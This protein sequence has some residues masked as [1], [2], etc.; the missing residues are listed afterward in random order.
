[1]NITRYLAVHFE[2]VTVAGTVKPG[3]KHGGKSYWGLLVAEPGPRKGPVKIPR[4][5]EG[6]QVLYCLLFLLLDATFAKMEAG[7]LQFP[8]V[9]S[10]ATQAFEE[11]LIKSKGVSKELIKL[12]RGECVK[13]WLQSPSPKRDMKKGLKPIAGP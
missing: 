9:L 13:L 1:M 6:F 2:V 4:E 7:Y 12:V 5:Q 10:E 11:L 8:L 3:T